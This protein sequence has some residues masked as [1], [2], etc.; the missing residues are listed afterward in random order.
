MMFRYALNH[1]N[2]LLCCISKVNIVDGS[3]RSEEEEKKE[4]EVNNVVEA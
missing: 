4:F 2:E 1:G 3:E